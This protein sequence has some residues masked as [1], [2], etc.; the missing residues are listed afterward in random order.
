[1]P[2]PLDGTA[3]F[4]LDAR[5]F[6]ASRRP[7]AGRS[8]FHFHFGEASGLPPRARRLSSRYSRHD[9][10]V[11][12]RRARGGRNFEPRRHDAHSGH[13]YWPATAAVHYHCFHADIVLTSRPAR[14]SR[15]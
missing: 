13:L 8:A 4:L 15:A 2:L 9:S 5:H 7:A 6:T 10:E 11:I 12:R 14:F 3:S 1:M